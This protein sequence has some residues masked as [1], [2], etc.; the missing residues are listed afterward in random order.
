LGFA[1]LSAKPREALEFTPAA[2][3]SAA[4]FL[5]AANDGR[6]QPDLLR[7]LESS[8]RAQV[9]ARGRP[10]VFRR[11]QSIFRQGEPHD[12]IYLIETGLTRVFYTAPTGREIT[13]A[14]WMPG[15]FCG[16]PEVFGAGSHIWSGAAVRDTRVLAFSGN[17]L[18]E[19]A[20]KHPP[21]A[22]GIIDSLVFKGICYSLLAQLLGTRSVVERLSGALY[23]MASV[24]G[25]RTPEGIEIAMAFTH[26]DLASMVGATR[27]WVS[28]TLRRFARQG[29][30]TTSRRR[31]II[32]QPERLATMS[33]ACETSNIVPVA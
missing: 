26:D 17:V 28:M 15:N 16:G 11:G 29:L 7:G 30:L 8:A 3:Q 32:V 18:R 25:R 9:L 20:D 31:L 27:Q 33:D 24:Y 21:L 5:A 22:I 23:Q 10:R 13:L 19:L 6:R 4:G 1:V 12:G 14:Y 2:S